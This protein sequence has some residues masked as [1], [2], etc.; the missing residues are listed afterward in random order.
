MRQVLDWM[1]AALFL[2]GMLVVGGGLSGCNG[3]NT[4]G[5]MEW[6][7]PRTTAPHVGTTYAIRGWM[8]VYSKGIDDMAR[9][10]NDR[11][12]TAYIFQDQQ[13]IELG[14]TMVE[15]YKADPN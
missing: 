15:R 1:R 4:P 7:Q 8:G 13:Y 6:V 9:A 5:K 10:I 3:V 2:C 12:S 14:K 11:G